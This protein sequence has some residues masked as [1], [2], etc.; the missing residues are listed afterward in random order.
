MPIHTFG[1]NVEMTFQNVVPGNTWNY[2]YS[3]YTPFALG[4]I[5]ITNEIAAEVDFG[6]EH[7]YSPGEI[8]SFRVSKPYGMIELNNKQA[9]VLAIT[10][11][12]ITVEIDTR[13]FNAFVYPPVGLVEVPALCVPA[14]SGVVPGLYTPTMNLED[15]FD[16]RP[17]E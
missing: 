3:D 15:S 13:T 7:P 12:T 8:V 10:D 16:N 4:I 1:R 6:M 2:T 11:T 14:G 17:L 5:G 9:R